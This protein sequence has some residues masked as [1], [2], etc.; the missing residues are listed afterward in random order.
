MDFNGSYLRKV[1]N[2]DGDIE[3]TFVVKDFQ[4]QTIL[5]ELEKDKPYRFNINPIKSKRTIEQNKLLWSLIHEISIA[6]G[7]DRAN[8]DMDI[9]IE[10][11]QKSGAKYTYIASIP[12]AEDFI[13]RQ[14]RAIQYLNSFTSEK[15]VK[16]N[17]YRVYYGSSSMDTKEMTN[18]LEIVLD[19]AAEVGVYARYE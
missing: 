9:Y 7:G 5:N 18:L 2:E 4:S 14:F 16:M 3:V 19:M 8:D 6:R 11:L 1:T 10:A 17:Q 13:K 12:E 15:G